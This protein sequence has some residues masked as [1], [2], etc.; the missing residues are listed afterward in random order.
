MFADLERYKSLEKDFLLASI[1]N[2]FSGLVYVPAITYTSGFQN[3]LQTAG[4]VT[5][6]VDNA[7]CV[8][9]GSPTAYPAYFIP[10][11][12]SDTASLAKSS[13]N[14]TTASLFDLFDD[15]VLVTH[16]NPEYWYPNNYPLASW[17]RPRQN[18]YNVS[19]FFHIGSSKTYAGTINYHQYSETGLFLLNLLEVYKFAP[20]TANNNV[21]V[22]VTSSSLTYQPYTA[23]SGGIQSLPKNTIINYVKRF[24]DRLV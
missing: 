13:V 2:Q 6:N 19:Y 3:Q 23:S 5:I 21:N 15:E 17:N 16:I 11:Y 10:G 18:P 22:R 8:I 14:L 1:V 24:P 12:I 9:Q 7:T 20:S 4:A